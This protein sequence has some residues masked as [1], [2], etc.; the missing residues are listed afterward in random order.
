MILSNFFTYTWLYKVLSKGQQY[1]LEISKFKRIVIV[2]CIYKCVDRPSSS[3]SFFLIQPLAHL[4]TSSL[5][6][7]I[8]LNMILQLS[9]GF[10]RLIITFKFNV[11][12]GP[13]I[14]WFQ[15]SRCRRSSLSTCRSGNSQS[16]STQGLRRRQLFR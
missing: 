5:L 13:N 3:F 4:K 12:F 11:H 6:C 1:Q 14:V 2:L 10:C 16:Q 15:K 9:S 8:P 7:Y